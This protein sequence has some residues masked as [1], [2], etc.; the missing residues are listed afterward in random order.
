MPVRRQEHAPERHCEAGFTLL[1]VLV[2]LAVVAISLAAIGSLV[3]GTIRSTRMLDE[4]VALRETTRAV[5]TALP[6]RDQLAAGNVSGQ[7]DDFRWRLDVLPFAAPFVDPSQPSPWIPQTVV[8]R[9]LSP[10][11]QLLR[12]DTVRL[13]RGEASRR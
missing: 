11:G 3:A 5:F 1:E 7:I 6:D 9:V 2:A 12:I 8:L 4:R 10:S 13:Q